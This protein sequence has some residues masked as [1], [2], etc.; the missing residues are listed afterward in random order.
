MVTLMTAA[1][2]C[3]GKDSNVRDE[4][5]DGM[6]AERDKEGEAKDLPRLHVRTTDRSCLQ[7]HAHPGDE[8]EGRH[9]VAWVDRRPR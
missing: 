9:G 3:E 2:G 5:D 6:Q 8:G 7:L 4:E 1:L